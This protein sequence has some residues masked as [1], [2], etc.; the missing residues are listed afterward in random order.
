[1]SSFHFYPTVFPILHNEDI[2]LREVLDRD[3]A[4]L[5]EIS[6]Y[7]G[8]RAESIEEATRMQ[9]KIIQDYQKG[10]SIHWLIQDKQSHEVIGTCGYYR[11]F[12]NKKGELGCI[13]LPTHYSKGYMRQAL[14]LAIEYGLKEIKLD[15]IFAITTSDN[16]QAIRLLE[17]L[18]FSK[19][20][21]LEHNEMKFE[22]KK[23]KS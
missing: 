8:K 11:G 3:I 12:D 21:D 13:L 18:N 4:K 23:K 14:A 19:I 9:Q 20:E 5:V 7:D 17:W 16:S 2:I 22:L 10:N 6:F 15:R 1:M